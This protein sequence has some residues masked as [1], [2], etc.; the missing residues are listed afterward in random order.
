MEAIG[1][2]ALLALTLYLISMFERLVSMLLIILGPAALYMGILWLQFRKRKKFSRIPLKSIPRPP[3]WSLQQRIS[4]LEGKQA[5]NVTILVGSSALGGFSYFIG[6]PLMFSLS[7]CAVGSVIGIVQLYKLM[8]IYANYKLGLMGEQSVG[9]ILNTLSRDTIQVYHDYEIQEPGC[10]PWNID[11][12]VVSSEG[13]FLIET[14]T[15][16]KLK[17]KGCNG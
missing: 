3:G 7:I 9:A 6:D 10:K 13:V 5:I 14:K 16:R 11:H 8:P 15:R 2:L 4:E 12:I 17:G 1:T